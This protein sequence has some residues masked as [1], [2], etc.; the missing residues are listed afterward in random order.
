MYFIQASV[1]NIIKLMTALPPPCPNC[2]L[3]ADAGIQTREIHFSISQLSQ[4]RHHHNS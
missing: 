3:V 1:G 4:T 2:F